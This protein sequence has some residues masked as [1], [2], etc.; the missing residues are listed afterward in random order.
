MTVHSH[1]LG[2]GAYTGPSMN[3][4]VQA[5]ANQQ[6]NSMLSPWITSTHKDAQILNYHKRLFLDSLQSIWTVP[7]STRGFFFICHINENKIRVQ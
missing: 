5:I 3:Q 7:S 2:L 6:L 4:V 1:T